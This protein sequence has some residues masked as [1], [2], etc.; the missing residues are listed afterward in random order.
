MYPPSSTSGAMYNGVP[1]CPCYSFL[2]LSL[3][4]LLRP[5]SIILTSNVSS[6]LSS[7]FSGFISLCAIPC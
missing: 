5:K 3:Y 2:V 4:F 7:K 1:T 6:E